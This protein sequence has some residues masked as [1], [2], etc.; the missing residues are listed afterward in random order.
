M[1]RLV[2]YKWSFKRRIAKYKKKNKIIIV[3]RI[4]NNERI[5]NGNIHEWLNCKND[6]DWSLKSSEGDGN[7]DIFRSNSFILSKFKQNKKRKWD[8]LFSFF[9]L[10]NH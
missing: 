3:N 5:N 2:R 8:F 9:H 10:L 7:D 4:P 1:N 6:I